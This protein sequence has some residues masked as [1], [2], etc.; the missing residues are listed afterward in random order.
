[1]FACY[2]VVWFV[3]VKTLCTSA[4]LVGLRVPEEQRV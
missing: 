1:M 3:V 4:L 2:R